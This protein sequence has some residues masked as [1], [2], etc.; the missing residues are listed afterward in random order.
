MTK[1]R[2]KSVAIEVCNHYNSAY[3]NNYNITIPTLVA[4]NINFDDLH[5]YQPSHFYQDYPTT[6]ALIPT[7]RHE[8]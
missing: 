7:S 5:T 6:F 2:N 8:V 1:T 3:N 4:M